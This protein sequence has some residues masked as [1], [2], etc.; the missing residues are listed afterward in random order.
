MK[1]LLAAVFATLFAF[2]FT[3]AFATSAIK[4]PAGTILSDDEK[5]DEEKAPQT[6][7]KDQKDDEDKKGEDEKKSN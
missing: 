7:Q 5:K 2:T 6:D 3:H 4:A 1:K